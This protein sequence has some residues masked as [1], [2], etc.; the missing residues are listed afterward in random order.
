VPTG[1]RA[2]LGVARA[3]LLVLV[4]A[5]ALAQTPARTALLVARPDLPDPNFRES[6][7]LVTRNEISGAIGVI[8]NRPTQR[9][10]AELLSGERFRR[11]SEPVFFGGPVSLNGLF[12]LFRAEKPPGE[13]LSLLPGV[14]LALHPETLDALLGNPPEVIR[15][16]AGYSGWAPEQLESELARGDWLVVDADAETVFRKDPTNLWRELTLR[17]RAVHAG[18]TA[19]PFRYFH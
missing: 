19:P 14:H 5:G 9:S 10:L 18:A 16:F 17:A 2:A 4:A 15:F 13:A 6:V 7:V 3:L 12:A 8:I 1:C 11:F